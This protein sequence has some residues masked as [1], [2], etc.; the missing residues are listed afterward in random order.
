LVDLHPDNNISDLVA[1]LKK[2]SSRVLRQ[3][4]KPEIDKYYWGKAKG[5]TPS[6]LCLAQ[7]RPS[8][9]VKQYVREQ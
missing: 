9:I 1:S 7:E 2:A 4:F 6:V 8:E 5:T 3:K